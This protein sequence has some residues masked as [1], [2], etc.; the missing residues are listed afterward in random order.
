MNIIVLLSQFLNELN[1][2]IIMTIKQHPNQ[3]RLAKIPG[4]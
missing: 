1:S 4:K 3:S 2:L